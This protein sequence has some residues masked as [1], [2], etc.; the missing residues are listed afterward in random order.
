MVSAQSLW[1]GNAL[2]PGPA[3]VDRLRA[4]VPTL[5][6]VMLLDELE[7][8]AKGAAPALKQF[9]SAV[10]LLDRIRPRAD[11][12]RN[13][14]AAV[15]DWIVALA[16]RS[17]RQDADRNSAQ[18]GTLIPPVVKALQGWAPA[19]QAF[20]MNWQPAMRP[21]YGRDLSYFPLVFSIQVV[22]A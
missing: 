8:G 7:S 14:A 12:Q 6:E 2:W 10:V 4:E 13:K 1:L 22:T 5:R 15:Q 16:A 17:A 18:I 11:D 3:I 20:A 9:P 21:N 19:E